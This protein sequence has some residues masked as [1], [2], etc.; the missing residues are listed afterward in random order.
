MKK[1]ILNLILMLLS[2]IFIY[3][4]D[5]SNVE[6]T[7]ATDEHISPETYLEQIVN[8]QTT[9]LEEM[10]N[11]NTAF[12]NANNDEILDTYYKLVIVITESNSE[13]KKLECYD[14]NDCE[15][16]NAAQNL[17]NFYEEIANFEFKE[18]VDLFTT[19]FDQ[20]TEEDVARLEEM[21]A[22]T[23]KEEEKLDAALDAAQKSFASK[24]DFTIKTNKLQ[25]EIDNL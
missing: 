10:L 15:L 18:M 1:S 3:S 23:T 4:C 20:I 12:N 25:N 16:R 24:H 2:L 6:N 5:Y 21:V 7:A 9:V 14:K 17:F 13:I 8:I 22:N 19:D 11:L